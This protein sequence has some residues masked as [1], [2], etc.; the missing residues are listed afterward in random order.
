M[1]KNPMRD[2]PNP[3]FVC[4]KKVN[5]VPFY[6]FLEIEKRKQIPLKTFS[7]FNSAY[8]GDIK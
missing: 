4:G 1:E 7:E 8:L 3:F 6:S 2:A 5:A